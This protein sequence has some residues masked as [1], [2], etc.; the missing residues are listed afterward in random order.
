MILRQASPGIACR[1]SAVEIWRPVGAQTMSDMAASARAKACQTIAYEMGPISREQ[2]RHLRNET[3]RRAVWQLEARVCTGRG[4]AHS[5]ALP[6]LILRDQKHLFLHVRHSDQPWRWQ[7]FVHHPEVQ[8]V[9]HYV[10]VF[11]LQDVPARGVS[12]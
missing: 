2:T 4:V 9:A 3:S 5:F 1:D 8:V 6:D 12:L 7:V 11:A 10:P